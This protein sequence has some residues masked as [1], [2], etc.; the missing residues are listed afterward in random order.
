MAALNIDASLV[1][2]NALVQKEEK[3]V[4]MQNGCICC[5]LREDLLEEVTRLAQDGAFDYLIIERCALNSVN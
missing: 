1:E 5:T 3:V 4:K 2:K